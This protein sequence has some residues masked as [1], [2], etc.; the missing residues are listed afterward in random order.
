[1]KNKYLEGMVDGAIDISTIFIKPFTN[2]TER[3]NKMF[4]R[5]REFR[6]NLNYNLGLISGRF[7]GAIVEFPLISYELAKGVNYISDKF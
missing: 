2:R 4:D 7:V 5:E 3:Q 6:K 1:M